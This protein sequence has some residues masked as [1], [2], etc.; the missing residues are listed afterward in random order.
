[1]Q[2]S[3]QIAGS[4]VMTL[5]VHPGEWCGAYGNVSGVGNTWYFTSYS[6][7]TFP[8]WNWGPYC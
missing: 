1:M 2:G 4:N 8:V 3:V 7:P 5:Y 6:S